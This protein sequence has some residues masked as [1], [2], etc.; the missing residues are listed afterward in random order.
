MTMINTLLQRSLYCSL[1]PAGSDP[2]VVCQKKF[3]LKVNVSLSGFDPS[4]AHGKVS[5]RG[6]CV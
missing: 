3:F 6:R 5:V 2:E 4:I 1:R